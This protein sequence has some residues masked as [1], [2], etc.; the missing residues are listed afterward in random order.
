MSRVLHPTLLYTTIK[1]TS[2]SRKKF[3]FLPPH[4]RELAAGEEYTI[5]GSIH[6]AV[7]GADR[8][9]ARRNMLALERALTQGDLTIVHTPSIVLESQVASEEPKVAVL[10]STNQLQLAPS[11]T[12]P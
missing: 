1:N 8:A 2:G 4:G 10:N 11:F 7:C 12:V 5:F 9:T 3:G 6:D